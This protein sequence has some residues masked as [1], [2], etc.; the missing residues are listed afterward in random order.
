LDGRYGW[1]DEAYQA[2]LEAGRVGLIIAPTGT[3]KT[4]LFIR[5]M[6]E[7]RR[8]FYVAPTRAAIEDIEKRLRARHVSGAVLMT[9]VA[10][11][12]YQPWLM[13]GQSSL[14][15]ERPRALV[16]LDEAHHLS[17][18][19]WSKILLTLGDVDVIG[20]TATAEGIPAWPPVV[21][22]V[23]MDRLRHILPPVEAVVDVVPPT[24][25]QLALYR[26]LTERVEALR[27]RLGALLREEAPEEAVGRVL[28][29]IAR[30]ESLKRA[31]SMRNALKLGTAL[32]RMASHG[33]TITFVETIEQARRLERMARRAGLDAVAVHDG[34]PGLGEAR[35][36]RHII[37]V[38]MLDEGVNMPEVEAL[39]FLTNPKRM[40]RAVQR[41]GRGL[42]GDKV[43]KAYIITVFDEC[44]SVG[45]YLRRIARTVE[46]GPARTAA[47][48]DGPPA[49]DRPIGG[50]GV[51]SCACAAP[52][53]GAGERGDTPGPVA[54]PSECRSYLSLCQ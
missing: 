19:T 26:D 33:R 21:Y 27:R 18:P 17:A 45:R 5:V 6:R 23:G 38:R 20:G 4:E 7:Y 29:Q 8:K 24:A 42:R 52:S 32:R 16:V 15:G 11:S 14:T 36:H 31:A 35:Q 12:E 53:A 37:A 28:I 48:A 44:E 41:V 2:W 22:E 1:Q 43:L 13:N 10:A 3:G 40:R 9:Y 50:G 54:N 46:V 47:R 30:L 49:S 25:R 39:I 34:G 51:E